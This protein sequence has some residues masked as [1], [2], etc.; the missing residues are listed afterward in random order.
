MKINIKIL[1]GVLSIL[2]GLWIPILGFGIGLYGAVSN[3]DDEKF[4]G[5]TLN[6]VGAF[7]SL[8]IIIINTISYVI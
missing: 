8:G 2:C 6:I 5:L 4:I 3:F 1:L 7:M